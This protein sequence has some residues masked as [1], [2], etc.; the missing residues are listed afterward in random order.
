MSLGLLVAFLGG[1]AQ[2]PDV[3]GLKDSP[4]S[5]RIRLSCYASASVG[6]V[7]GDPGNMGTHS[8]EGGGGE[9]NGI[10][11][12]C[13]AGHIDVPHLRKAADWTAYLA[14]KTFNNLREG[15][16][17][18]SF[19][20]WEP[21]RYF[22]HIEYPKDWQTLSQAE[23]DRY[24]REV[25]IRLG[26]YFAFTGLTWHEM[27]T[28]FGYRPIAYYPEFSSAFSWEDNFSNLLG[29]HLAVQALRDTRRSYDE[30]MTVLL[31][32]ELELLGAQ[33]KE[34]TKHASKV[35]KGDWYTGSF[36]F[37]T[38]IKKRNLDLGLGDGYVTPMIIP[39]IP[40]CEGAEPRAYPVPTLDSV[41]ELGFSVKL[42]IQPK[43]IEK[44]KILRVVYPDR[45]QRKKRIEPAVH[46]RA[47][48]E[49]IRQDARRRYG[50]DADVPYAGAG[51]ISK[52]P[53]PT[54]PP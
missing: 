33:P 26:Y 5:P 45:E 23:K 40:G 30:A 28:W 46:F 14:R 25:S 42:E 34:T 52:A 35:V 29:T 39:G 19:K 17:E 7:Y 15:Q 24:A 47:I 41:R 27:L 13:K 49:H 6:T 44:G 1:C 53:L 12:T 11:Y 21:S 50:P 16:T 38:K 9:K 37:L 10:I 4:D 2:V 3:L 20:F 48:I 54:S 36:L 8:Y 43:E 22:V 31:D 51:E 18:F 32:R